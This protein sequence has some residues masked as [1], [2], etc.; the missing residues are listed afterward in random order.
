MEI[1]IGGGLL[2]GEERVS[3]V[4]REQIGVMRTV[5]KGLGSPV[6]HFMDLGCGD[7]ILAVVIL[8]EFPDSDGVL[9]TSS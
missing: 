2:P 4:I 9:I 5:I 1:R 8:E 7:G 6:N 3:T